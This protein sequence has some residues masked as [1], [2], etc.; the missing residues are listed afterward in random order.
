MFPRLYQ[1]GSMQISK[2]GPKE[3]SIEQRGLSLNRLRHF[4]EA[5][6]AALAATFDAVAVQTY[7]CLKVE[8]FNPAN[9]ETLFRVAWD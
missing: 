7:S 6:V 4:R 2:L 1:G 5:Q 9:D 3:M 8:R